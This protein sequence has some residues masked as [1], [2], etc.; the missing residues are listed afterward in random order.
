GSGEGVEQPL[1]GGPTEG[2]EGARCWQNGPGWAACLQLLPPEDQGTS[3]GW[4]ASLMAQ[5][6][7]KQ[8]PSPMRAVLCMTDPD[9][10]AARY[11]FPKPRGY[12]CVFT[13]D[14]RRLACAGG[15]ESVAV[16]DT[17][18]WPRWPGAVAA[19]VVA[20]GSVLALGWHRRPKGPAA[21]NSPPT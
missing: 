16:W 1:L 17:D 4:W 20:A 3:H 21:P 6:G 18:P 12:P 14:G 7:A 9:S 2:A 8:D 10:G 5:L 11:K 15:S 13:P 19:G